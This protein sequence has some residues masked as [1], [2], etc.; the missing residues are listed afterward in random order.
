M[1]LAVC[2]G[3]QLLGHRFRTNDGRDLPGFGLLDVETGP[4]EGVPRAVGEITVEVDVALGIPVL[5]GFENHGGR[6]SLGPGARPLGRVLTGVGNTGTDGTEGA[7]H[8]TVVG[9]YLHG[10]CWCGTR[11][12]PTCCVVGGGP[13]EPLREPE[14]EALRRERLAAGR[15]RVGVVLRPVRRRWLVRGR[16]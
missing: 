10:R 2:A 6:T 15:V 3:Y 14:V 7:Y 8:G 11:R 16:P 9:T 1:P 4:G 13:L 12:W 5:T